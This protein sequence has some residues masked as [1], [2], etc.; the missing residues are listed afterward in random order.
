[1]VATTVEVEPGGVA[2]MEVKR[3]GTVTEPE[4][5]ESDGDSGQD[6]EPGGEVLEGVS[7]S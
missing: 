5:E 6:G 2:L 4:D 1:M 7:G 3:D